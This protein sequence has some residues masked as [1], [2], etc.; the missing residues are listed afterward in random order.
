M[1]TRIKEYSANCRLGQAEKSAIAEHALNQKGHEIRFQDTQVL[2]Q[3]AHY[4]TR[5]FLE[6]IEIHK[7]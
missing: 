3:S 6:A 4:H 7:H 1:N 5:L 2:A